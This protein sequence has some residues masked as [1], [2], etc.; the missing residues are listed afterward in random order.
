M[1]SCLEDTRKV[2]QFIHDEIS[3]EAFVNIM[4]QYY[5]CHRASEHPEIARRITAEEY[6]SA[7]KFAQDIGLKRA[8][9]H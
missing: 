8:G 9:G 4:P 3:E 2:V 1:P 5:P 6:R 7:L